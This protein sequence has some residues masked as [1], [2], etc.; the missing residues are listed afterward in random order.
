MGWVITTAFFTRCL[1]S[2]IDLLQ[3]QACVLKACLRFA[4]LLAL[5][6]AASVLSARADTGATV[7]EIVAMQVE[8]GDDSLLLSANLKFDLP[9]QVEDALRQGIPM[10]FMA[11]AQLQRERWYW[12]DQLVSTA[13]RYYRLSHQPLTRRWRL[14]VSTTPFSSAGLGLAL[15]QTFEQLEDAMAAIQRLSRWKIAEGAPLAALSGLSGVSV[16]LRFRLDLTQLPR[17][18]Q[19]GALGRTGWNLQLAKTIL[20]EPLP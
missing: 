11:E 5:V 18:L 2:C 6:L 9:M 8:L 19:I 13:S 14:H 4:P 10:Y 15:G 16:Q 7:T 3:R 12:S 1:R 17:P 20:L